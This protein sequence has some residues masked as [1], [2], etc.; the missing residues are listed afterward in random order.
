MW[1][2]ENLFGIPAG[3]WEGWHFSPADAQL[4]SAA[5]VHHKGTDKVQ[6]GGTGAVHTVHQNGTD[7]VQHGGAGAVHILSTKR[8]Q[9]K[10]NMVGLEPCTL[11]THIPGCEPSCGSPSLPFRVTD[12]RTSVLLDRVEV[13]HVVFSGS[14]PSW[15]T[16]WASFSVG[17]WA[18]LGCCPWVCSGA[19]PKST[20]Q[21]RLVHKQ[22]WWWTSWDLRISSDLHLS[23]AVDATCSTG[24]F[25]F[26]MSGARGVHR[27]KGFQGLQNPQPHCVNTAFGF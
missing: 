13:A 14:N 4:L 12:S 9:I 16:H 19:L 8:E 5:H 17:S 26:T 20:L 25:H 24:E 11:S 3:Q 27:H 15:Q 7:K 2:V 23:S 1:W 10:F 21:H 18:W 6:H 22:Q